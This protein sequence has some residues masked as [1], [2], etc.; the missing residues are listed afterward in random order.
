M[1]DSLFGWYSTLWIYM[2][3]GKDEGNVQSVFLYGMFRIMQD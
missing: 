1:Y 2:H 3:A